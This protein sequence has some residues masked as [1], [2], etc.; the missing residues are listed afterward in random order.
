MAEDGVSAQ[1]GSGDSESNPAEEK[2]AETER[3]QSLE[4]G[5][6]GEPLASKKLDEPSMHGAAPRENIFVR[7]KAFNAR[8]LLITLTMMLFAYTFFFVPQVRNLWYQ[9]PPLWMLLGIE[10]VLFLLAALWY[11]LSSLIVAIDHQVPF[12]KRDRWQQIVGYPGR[13]STSWLYR[14]VSNP[15]RCRVT[16]A[17]S[18]AL[19]LGTAVAAYTVVDF[20]R[21]HSPYVLSGSF[22]AFGGAS[23]FAVSL[24]ILSRPL[25]ERLSGQPIGKVWKVVGYTI[26][27]IIATIG[28]S[29]CLWIAACYEW[30][31][32][33]FRIYTIWAC[34]SV[35]GS[36]VAIAA[37]LDFCHVYSSWPVRQLCVVGIIGVLWLQGP[38][39]VNENEQSEAERNAAPVA[40]LDAELSWVKAALT[41][42][43]QMPPGPVVICAASGGGSRAAIYTT[44]VLEHLERTKMEIPPLS[45][46]PLSGGTWGDHVLFVSAVSGGSL[47]TANHYFRSAHDEQGLVASIRKQTAQITQVVDKDSIPDLKNSTRKELLHRMEKHIE[48]FQETEGDDDDR[49][50]GEVTDT[51]LTGVDGEPIDVSEA[52][53][54]GY[55]DEAAE[56]LECW[57]DSSHQRHPLDWILVDEDVDAMSRDYM[58]PI[59]RGALLPGPRGDLL[60][61]FWGHQFQWQGVTTATIESESSS[62]DAPLILLNASDIDAGRQIV[63]GF[64]ELPIRF[65]E[66]GDLI[67]GPD[68]FKVGRPVN[69]QAVPVGL[70]D[71]CPKD[72]DLARAV[73]LSSNF[74]FGFRVSQLPVYRTLPTTDPTRPLARLAVLDG[75]V[76]D[77]TGIDSVTQLLK[78]LVVTGELHP[79]QQN[80]SQADV[81]SQISDKSRQLL[82]QIR[83]RGVV[84]VEID[85]GAKPFASTGDGPLASITHPINALGNASF[86]GALRAKSVHRREIEELL[87]AGLSIDRR[88]TEADRAVEDAIVQ[89][90]RGTFGSSVLWL[91]FECNHINSEHAE[92]MTA[93]AL[94]PDD[95]AMILAQFVMEAMEFEEDAKRY[96]DVVNTLRSSLVDARADALHELEQWNAFVILR[97][98][99]QLETVAQLTETGQTEQAQALWRDIVQNSAASSIAEDLIAEDLVSVAGDIEL[100]TSKSAVQIQETLK[101]L[102]AQQVPDDATLQVVI[103]QVKDQADEAKASVS[104]SSSGWPNASLEAR[105]A[106]EK[107]RAF[108]Q[109]QAQ[110]QRE[111]RQYYMNKARVLEQRK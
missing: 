19:A 99:E 10:Y 97:K 59:L 34:L 71:V 8:H 107:A 103:E 89:K 44:L 43:K 95:K 84:F 76:V 109:W 60:S 7:L 1:G 79:Q 80:P 93:W 32:V 102:G 54:F 57:E 58:A 68:E 53:E 82:K 64:P 12:M 35:A 61:A 38:L 48:F 56:F 37:C 83:N 51:R 63:M 25:F 100:E 33:S 62:W 15:L 40:D 45:G 98:L 87:N 28:I 81:A 39:W 4:A 111:S 65:L 49:T 52:A 66:R 18:F 30:F 92:V 78:A 42:V 108:Q 17:V 22:Y 27:W 73:R 3:L 29:E 104:K 110:R 85:S 47:A 70:H 88:H 74:P 77:N 75:G 50:T 101:Q 16:F 2:P 96:K 72:V 55:A 106:R 94:G 67:P 46:E 6:G 26:G 41:R 86:N 13:I 24:W 31:H 90:Y 105:I 9:R 23:G 5:A 36:V 91:T 14:L 11:F 69:K 21:V 20:D